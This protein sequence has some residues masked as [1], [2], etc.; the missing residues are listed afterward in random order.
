MILTDAISLTIK[1]ISSVTFNSSINSM[2]YS[3]VQLSTI[4]LRR[5]ITRVSAQYFSSPVIDRQERGGIDLLEDPTAE[6]SGCT[7]DTCLKPH[8][9]LDRGEARKKKGSA[10]P[11]LYIENM[12]FL[13]LMETMVRCYVR[14]R[15]QDKNIVIFSG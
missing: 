9:N 1:K 10:L 5:E 15:S 4:F 3:Y 6:V 11:V 8:C 14:Y 12:F 2:I 13:K 7:L